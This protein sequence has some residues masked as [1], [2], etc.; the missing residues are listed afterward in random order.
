[1]SLMMQVFLSRERMVTPV[2]WADAI[3]AQG[4]DMQL[5]TDFDI[6]TFTG[7]LPCRYKGKDAG[8]EYFFE[9]VSASELDARTREVVGDRDTLVSF[10]THSG[11]RDLMTSVIA[12]GVLCSITGGVLLDSEA[13]E[14]TMADAAVA[15]AKQGERS[16]GEY[17]KE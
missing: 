2:Q 8:F 15:W 9:P 10:T 16:I 3:R 11:F 17:F 1:M 4:F 5:D 13:D 14:F 6:R 7:F 12:S